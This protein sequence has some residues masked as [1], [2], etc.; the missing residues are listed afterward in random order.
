MAKMISL[1]NL[2]DG[3]E[4]QSEDVTGYLDGD[5]G[6]VVLIGEEIASQSKR[7]APDE[8][9]DWETELIEVVRAVDEGSKRYVQLP[10]TNDWQIMRGFCD[11]VEGDTVREPLLQAI[12]GRSAFRRF[13]D[14][15][16][17]NGM[18]E[19]WFAFKRNALREVAIEWCTENEIVFGDRAAPAS[20]RMA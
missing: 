2:I 14:E 5:T 20:D 12:H 8:W 9:S 10:R 11:S 17:R 19:P 3:I 6:A 13:K 15:L 7:D 16:R 18:L 1:D 4:M